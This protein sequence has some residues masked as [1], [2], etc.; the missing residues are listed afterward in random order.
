M[1][2]ARGFLTNTAVGVLIVLPVYLAVLVLLKGMQSVA[3]FVRPFAMLLPAWLP[4]EKLLSLVLVVI[5]CTLIGIARPHANGSGA[6][7]TIGDIAL[8]EASGLRAVPKSHTAALRR[9]PGE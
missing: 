7:G 2:F 9:G 6:P 1:N 4:A 5:G 8:R 3:G